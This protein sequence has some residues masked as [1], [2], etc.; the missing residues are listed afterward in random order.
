M[1]CRMEGRSGQDFGFGVMPHV[2]QHYTHSW[3]QNTIIS[4][5]PLSALACMPGQTL[6]CRAVP[7]SAA[8]NGCRSKTGAP[9]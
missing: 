2:M 6:H 9:T 8:A 5:P 4:Y 1:L 3:P 7:R